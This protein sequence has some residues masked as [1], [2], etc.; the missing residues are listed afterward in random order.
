VKKAGHY[1]ALVLYNKR[2]ARKPENKNNFRCLIGC[3]WLLWIG[4]LCRKYHLILLIA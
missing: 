2:T 1:T 4:L 3:E